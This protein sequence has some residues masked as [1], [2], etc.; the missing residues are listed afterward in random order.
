MAK[1][2]NV[3]PL[4]Y[5]ALTENPDTRADDF[6]LLLEVYK[7]FINGDLTFETAIRHHVELG[8]PS[9][10][11]IPRIRRKLQKQYP[12]LENKEAVKMRKEEQKEYKAYALNN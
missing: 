1:I 3:E 5:K 11:S 4:V 6:L 7:N 9:Y 8:L 12:E 2:A 10:V